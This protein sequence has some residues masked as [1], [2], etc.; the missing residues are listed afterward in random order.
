M[1]SQTLSSLTDNDLVLLL[2]ESNHTAFEELYNRYWKKTLS[3]AIHKS[4]DLNEA[5]NMVQD[6]FVSLWNRREILVINTSFNN[7]LFVSVKYRVLKYLD[8]QRSIRLYQENTAFSADI[9]DDSTQQYLDFEELKNKL[10]KLICALPEKTSLIYRMNKDEGMSHREIAQ[11]LNMTEK[12]VNSQLVRTK[13]ILRN[14]LDTFLCN[15]LL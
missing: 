14:G 10:E 5:E 9:L 7:Y 1:R 15:F 8:K 4:G 3:L 6:I 12:A 2:Q 11:S 13:K